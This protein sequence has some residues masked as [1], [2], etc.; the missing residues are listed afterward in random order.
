MLGRYQEGDVAQVQE[1]QQWKR[2]SIV[3]DSGACENVINPESTPGYPAKETP[4]SK[5][6]HAFT[7]AIGDPIP[8]LGSIKLPLVTGEGSTKQLNFW[9]AEV[10]KPLASVKRICAAGHTCVFDEEGSF[11]FNKTTGEYTM[12]QEESGS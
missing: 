9:A 11:I 12:L 1:E 5:A 6:G 3:V 7:A 4:A 10:T 8:N 2:L